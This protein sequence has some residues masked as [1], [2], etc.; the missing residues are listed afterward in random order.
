VTLEKFIQIS[1]LKLQSSSSRHPEQHLQGAW[2]YAQLGL[3]LFPWLPTVGIVVL[4]LVVL[5]VWKQQYRTLIRRPLNRGLAIL[6]GW[7]IIT[8]CFANNRSEAFL[9]LANLL[10]YFLVFAAYSTLIQTP[11]Q[12]RQM[13]RILVVG[14]LPVVIL[15][16]GQLFLGWA[17]LKPLEGVI[18]WAIAPGGNPP[19]RMASVFM[20]ANIL[21][22]YL[23]A[24]FIL[25]LGL[26]IETFQA[27]RQRW[28]KS[29]R[30]QLLFW[31]VLVVG[32][33]IALVLTNS[34]NVWGIAVLAWLA[35]A[36]YLG[37]R[38]LVAGVTAAVGSILWASFGLEPGRQWLRSLVPAFFWARLSDQLYPNRPVAQLRSTQWQFAWWMTQERPWLG[39]GLR[40]FTPLYEAKMHLWLGHPHNLLLMLTA[41]IGIP[42]T[43]LLCG[44]ISWVLAQGVLLIGVWSD[45]AP[46]AARYQ[47]HQD[48][49]IL[50]TYLVAFAGCTLFNLLDVTLFD[51]RVNTLGWLLLSA[52]CGVVYR[53]RALLLW[54]YFE[55]AANSK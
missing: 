19:G 53:Y 25:A 5:G 33:A 16:F 41:E 50:F 7:L 18:G 28:N 31:S 34:R 52:I 42:G 38:L 51:L 2:N 36:L 35:F 48:R 27:L 1:K 20:Y 49:L 30:G 6:S 11:G 14:S 12:L 21:A 37:W 13:A 54:R 9:G 55:K 10:P 44:L 17:G 8:C 24:V 29:Q 22:A 43:L 47:W 39:W 15:G 26:W 3:F 4:V 40:N 45:V 46:P 32:N 23:Q